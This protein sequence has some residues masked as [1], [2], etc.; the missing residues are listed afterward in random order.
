MK[1]L[2]ISATVVAGLLVVGPLTQ[3]VRA[4]NTA[5]ANAARYGVAV[6]D[7]SYIF[8]EYSRFKAQIDAMK[9]EVQAVET[10]LRTDRQEIA[11]SEE[12]LKQFKPGTPDYRT[13]DEQVSRRK[14]DFNLSATRQ[15]KDFME[16]EAKIYHQTY[17]EV[18]QA[19]T[20]YAQRNNIGLVLRFNGD[21]I[22]DAERTSVLRQINKP[23]IFQNGIDITGDI[24]AMLRQGGPG[25]P[26]QNPAARRNPVRGPTPPR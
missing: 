13:L 4:Q 20:F 16:R 8:K 7:I 18:S 9:N 17:L 22:Q 26:G 24:L 19:I 5:G 15:R 25:G 12:R 10:R 2:L 21:P 14:A 6:V 23:V 11:K 3:T 1:T